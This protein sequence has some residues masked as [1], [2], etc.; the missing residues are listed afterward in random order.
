MTVDEWHEC[1]EFLRH[2]PRL[3]EALAARGITDL[4]LVLVDTW[5]Y[6]AAL[7]PER[8]RGPADRLGRRLGAGDARRQPVRPPGRQPAPDHRPQRR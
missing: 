5:A 3:I 6:G 2:E 1:D 4:S 7:V 8:Y